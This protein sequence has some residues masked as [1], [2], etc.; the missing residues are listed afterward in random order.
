MQRARL[1]M[2]L[3]AQ[4]EPASLAAIV[5]PLLGLDDA[6]MARD[7]ALDGVAYSDPLPSADAE[8]LANVLASF[9]VHATLDRPEAV[10][11]RLESLDP[12]LVQSSASTINGMEGALLQRALN[13][14]EQGKA[15][16]RPRPYVHS[17]APP[18]PRSVAPSARPLTLDVPPLTEPEPDDLRTLVDARAPAV[19]RESAPPRRQRPPSAPPPPLAHPERA[20]VSAARVAPPVRPSA[21]RPASAN[22]APASGA[23]DRRTTLL[24]GVLCAASILL[25]AVALLR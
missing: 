6:Q 7:W 19:L 4:T 10:P 2:P 3:P 23:I 21:P 5:A 16:P 8:M 11:I 1:R 14:L 22:H 25:A 12:A 18:R 20:V 24:L 15:P 13:Y 9:N 17:S